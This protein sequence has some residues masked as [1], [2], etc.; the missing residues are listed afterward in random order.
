MASRREILL[1]LLVLEL[2]QRGK[3][4]DHIASFI[5][6]RRATIVAFYFA[7]ELM[8]GTFGAAVVPAEIVVAFGEIDVA[9]LEDSSPLEWCSMKYLTSR[10]M[11]ILS[12]QRLLP[13]QLILHTSTMTSSL[14][15]HVETFPSILSI[16][17][18]IVDLVWLSEFPVVMFAIDIGGVVA[19]G[20]DAFFFGFLWGRHFG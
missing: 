20:F 18:F 7:W 2:N 1:L 13:T 14:I 9:F 6:D 12:V 4:Q 15:Q 19:I 5:H 16:I 8:G 3:E 10:A 17:I 11:T